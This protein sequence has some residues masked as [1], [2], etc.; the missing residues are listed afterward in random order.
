MLQIGRTE[1]YFTLS[2]RM[3]FAE[4]ASEPKDLRWYDAGHMLNE[5]AREDRDRWLVEELSR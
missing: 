1:E 5:K 2:N 4:A 3:A